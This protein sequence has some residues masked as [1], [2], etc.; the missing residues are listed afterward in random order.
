MTTR[1][2]E[3]LV[4]F[5]LLLGLLAFAVLALRVSNINTWTTPDGYTVSALFE[6]IG[7][8]KPR[9]SVSA[10][11]VN[12]G[13]VTSIDYDRET[14]QAKVTFTVFNQFN[15]FPIDTSAAIFTAGLL[16]EQYIGLEPGAEDEYLTDG[17]EIEITQ[18]AMVL[19]QLIG[20]FIFSQSDDKEGDE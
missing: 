8:L 10:G 5:F 4:G 7:G 12:V 6:N 3:I 1:K 13:R 17:S 18:S 19:E 14:Y 15:T 9:S 11:G 16:G 20:Q 2:T